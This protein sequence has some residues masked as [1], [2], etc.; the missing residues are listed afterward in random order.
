VVENRQFRLNKFEVIGSESIAS[1][2]E[3]MVGHDALRWYIS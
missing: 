1:V 2:I 3:R